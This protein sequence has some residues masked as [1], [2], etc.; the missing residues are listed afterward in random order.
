LVV[1]ARVLVRSCYENFFWIGGLIAEGDKFA[2]KM[3]HADVKSK[4]TRAEFIYQGE[5]AEGSANSVEREFVKIALAAN[6]HGMR[7]TLRSPTR[8]KGAHHDQTQG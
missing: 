4:Q 6:G 5:C 3:L 7:V 1:E 2:K 8:S